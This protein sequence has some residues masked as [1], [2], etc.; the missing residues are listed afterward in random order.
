MKSPAPTRTG[1]WVFLT[2]LFI[3]A[4]AL[5]H[6]GW[7]D[8][9]VV[10]EA[11]HIA[12]GMVH[13]VEGDFR[14]YHVNPPLMRLLG[15]APLIPLCPIIP[16]A[17]PAFGSADR[18]EFLLGR[19]FAELNAGQYVAYVRIAR[20]ASIAASLLASWL[21]WSLGRRHSTVAGWISLLLW[22]SC[23]LALGHGHLLTA[24][25]GATCLGLLTVWCHH[26][27]CDDPSPAAATR[28]GLAWGFAL[29]AKYTTLA[30]VAALIVARIGAIVIAPRQ[31]DEAGSPRRREVARL[32]VAT[33]VAWMTIQTGYAWEA[34][35]F[36]A[37]D[38]EHYPKPIWMTYP[39]LDVLPIPLPREFVL[40][41]DRQ[42]QD[43]AGGIRSYLDGVIAERGWRSYYLYAAAYK[44]PLGHLALLG[45]AAILTLTIRGARVARLEWAIGIALFA[46]ISSQ[47]GF[48]HH[49][50]YILP[51]LPFLYIAAGVTLAQRSRLAFVGI[52]ACLLASA[53]SV[54]HDHPNHISYFN[55]LAGGWRRGHRH[56]LDSNIDWGQDLL[57]LRA[58][59]DSRPD[60]AARPVSLVAYHSVDPSV[61]G[62]AYRYPSEAETGPPRGGTYII[63]V[64]ALMGYEFMTSDGR[65]DLTAYPR[66]AFAALRTRQ[67]DERIGCSFWVFR[68]PPAAGP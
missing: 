40:G 4:T 34:P 55:E 2:I 39:P 20:W 35:I 38:V 33:L 25:M 13:W 66:G 11:G 57:R 53:A 6:A 48:S 23:P 64:N 18:P 21:V 12:S 42:R 3:Q 65:G 45:A 19:K 7:C 46:L 62:I 41:I 32:V 26:R 16:M 61:F 54:A 22:I 8:S 28:S 17:D 27:E 60:E 37:V 9:V 5:V 43:F 56:L 58:W 52:T 63:S 10:D 24:D 29:L 68:I 1:R 15:T 31:R 14:P 36:R 49:F 59:L 67:P 44:M 50:R 51:A 30:V 47:A